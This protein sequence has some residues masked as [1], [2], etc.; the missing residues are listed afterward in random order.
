MQ[1]EKHSTQEIRELLTRLDEEAFHAY[2]ELYGR[3]TR[4]NEML[5]DELA[6]YEDL[7]QQIQT[8]RARL[9]R[10][11]QDALAVDAFLELEES[12]GDL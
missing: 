9:A 4:D 11:E 10:L 3:I 8:F 2:D 6:F 1:F 7:L 12:L 5:H